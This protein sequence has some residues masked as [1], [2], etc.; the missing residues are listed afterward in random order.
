MIVRR[1]LEATLTCARSGSCKGVVALFLPF[2]CGI[3]CSFGSRREEERE[4]WGEILA[5]ESVMGEAFPPSVSEDRGKNHDGNKPD[6]SGSGPRRVFSVSDL[7]GEVG[8]RAPLGTLSEKNLPQAGYEKA[9]VP[10]FDGTWN[11]V[12]PSL[13]LGFGIGLTQG[14]FKYRNKA[15]PSLPGTKTKFQR[16][17]F[18][19]WKESAYYMTRL[20]LLTFAFSN[21]DQVVLD[22]MA[23]RLPL[24]QS[25][26]RGVSG[27]LTGF[28]AGSW[29]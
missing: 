17:T 7:V 16:L 21:I 3:G 13:I 18:F 4:R 11:K 25:Q 27:S 28:F 8:T 2:P 24:D 12:W 5:S 19:I 1:D 23:D 14:V 6:L 29:R 20:G 9:E 26:L 22:T 10:F 15:I